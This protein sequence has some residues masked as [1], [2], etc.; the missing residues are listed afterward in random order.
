MSEE[1]ID[2]E[3]ILDGVI[4]QDPRYAREAY[5]F[6]QQALYF[7][8][9]K[10]GGSGEGGH[11]RGAQLLQ[12]VRELGLSQFGPMAR[13]VLNHWGLREGEDVGE[14]VYNMIDAGLMRKTEDDR[15]NDFSGIMKFDESLDSEAGW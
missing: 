13:T 11:I 10:Y 15:K 4:E 1:P 3:T 6:V 14:I 12:G 2:Y 9:E 8:R 5:L 7:Y